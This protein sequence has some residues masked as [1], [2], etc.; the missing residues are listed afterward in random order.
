MN[1][2][3]RRRLDR[4]NQQRRERARQHA[5]DSTSDGQPA[6][7][8]SA[9]PPLPGERRAVCTRNAASTRGEI[10]THAGG[11]LTFPVCMPCTKAMPALVTRLG[12]AGLRRQIVAN[13]GGEP[14]GASGAAL[15]LEFLNTYKK[16]LGFTRIC[17]DRRHAGVKR[18]RDAQNQRRA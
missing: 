9:T 12:F 16:V 14:A 17:T 1:N 4:R 10:G 13:L 15:Y 11:E 7:D 3:I 6:R 2:N 8:P 18:M 5:R